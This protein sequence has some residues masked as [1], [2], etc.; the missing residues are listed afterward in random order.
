V[1]P[2]EQLNRQPHAAT[3]SRVFSTFDIQ[4]RSKVYTNLRPWRSSLSVQLSTPHNCSSSSTRPVRRA[5]TVISKQGVHKFAA[6]AIVAKCT[7]IH[8]PQLQLQQYATR[9]AGA[10][11]TGLLIRRHALLPCR[12]SASRSD[13][14]DALAGPLRHGQRYAGPPRPAPALSRRTPRLQPAPVNACK[15]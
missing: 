11:C 15:V 3:H 12:L 10:D 13:C 8:T 4:A 7:A 6:M 14:T 9:A 5:P 2:S 1:W